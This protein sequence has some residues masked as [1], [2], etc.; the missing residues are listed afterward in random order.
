MHALFYFSAHKVAIPLQPAVRECCNAPLTN[1]KKPLRSK[2]NQYPLNSAT[3][4]LELF[5]SRVSIDPV[6]RIISKLLLCRRPAR[7]GMLAPRD[8]WFMSVSEETHCRV[9]DHAC[10]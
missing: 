9:H 2:R 8:L 3:F 1:D 4:E 5:A 7:W 6:N 10:C